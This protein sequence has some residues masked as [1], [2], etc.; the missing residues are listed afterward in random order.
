M[1]TVLFRANYTYTDSKRKGSGEPAFDGSS[2]DGLPLDKTP[3]HL[4]NVRL[5]W[6]ASEQVLAYVLGQYQGK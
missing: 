1:P 3:K 5:D 4:A 2:L 6:D